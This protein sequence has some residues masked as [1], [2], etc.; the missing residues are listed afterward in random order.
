VFIGLAVAGLAVGGA[1]AVAELRDLESGPMHLGQTRDD[2]GGDRCFA[3]T[4]RM[5]TYHHDRHM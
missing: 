3:D 1:E 4:S 2:G 5:S